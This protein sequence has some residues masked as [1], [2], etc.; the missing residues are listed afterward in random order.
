MH[1]AMKDRFKRIFKWLILVL[2]LISTV[3]CLEAYREIRKIGQEAVWELPSRI[4]S[5]ELMIRPGDDIKTIGLMQRL[6]RLRYRKADRISEPGEYALQG[7]YLDVYVR[8]F[9]YAGGSMTAQPLRMVLEGS[10]IESIDHAFSGRR[11]ESVLLEPE[12]ISEIFDRQL[13]DRTVVELGQCP[14]F[15]L[16]A[17]IATED[18]RF[19]RHWGIDFRAILRAALVNLKHG[20]IVEGGS[21]ITQQVIKN[22][23]LTSKRTFTRKIKETGM[24]FMLEATYSKDEILQLYVNEIYMGQWG[25]AGVYG[26][27]R[28]ARLFF[29]KDISK[30]SL[31][32][33]AL[34]AGIIRAPNRYS[35]Y[36]SPN[37]AIGRRNTVLELMYKQGHIEKPTYELAVNEPLELAPM[38][39]RARYAPYFVDYMLYSIKE[40]YPMNLLARGGYNIYTSIDTH[41]QLIAEQKLQH[42]VKN[43]R[44]KRGPMNGAVV[45]L[46]PASGEIRAMVGGED[47]ASS[48]FNRAV[49]IKRHMGSLVKPLVYYTALRHGSTLADMISEKPVSIDTKEGEKW[50]PE[51]YDKK[52][53][54][55]VLLVDAL[56]N[57]YNVATVNLGLD[58]GLDSIIG[59]VR[60]LLPGVEVEENPSILLGAIDSSPLSVAGM[61]AV[62][63]NHGVSVEPVAVKAIINDKGLEVYGRPQR[64]SNQLLDSSTVFLLNSALQQVITRGTA[65]NANMYGMPAGFCGK[66]GTTNDLRDS[67]FAAFSPELV[68]VVWL[69]N[70]EFK[71]VNLTGSSGAMPIA[72]MILAAVADDASWPVPGDVVFKDID[73][74]NGKLASS[75]NRDKLNLPFIRGTAPTERSREELPSF[76]EI[77]KPKKK[78]SWKWLNN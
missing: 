52:L 34:L 77:F 33:A 54:G 64:M 26:M 14:A 7:H 59:E 39:P 21:T 15:L 68:T 73:P 58:V 41:M 8:P 40:Q 29:D 17:I 27:A 42:G 72:S 4:F 74:Q 78:K 47:Y 22:V 5:S 53:H 28:A 55:D 9:D 63:A 35:P 75:W 43:L 49:Q 20:S 46:D 30:L 2:L 71:P 6:E 51:N 57:S 24:A 36:N 31:S 18:K 16:E 1:V 69:G 37:R 3:I 38:Q 44:V 13:E 25:H 12:V 76:F 61:F 10:R 48:Q 62:Y 50:Q 70:D 67:W 66:T 19:Y 45:M 23:F 32:E 56:I 60:S 11:L 65:R